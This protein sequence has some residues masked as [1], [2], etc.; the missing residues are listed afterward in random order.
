VRQSLATGPA[1]LFGALNGFWQFAALT[2]V[3][4]EGY[5]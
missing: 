3:L 1:L 5:K 2:E 4:G